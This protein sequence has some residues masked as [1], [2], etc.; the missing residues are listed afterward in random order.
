MRGGGCSSWRRTWRGTMRGGRRGSGGISHCSRPSGR[1]ARPPPTRRWRSKAIE[2]ASRPRSTSSRR[3]TGRYCCYGIRDYRT[4]RLPRRRD[5][6]AA[7][8]GRPCRG[9][10]GG[11]CKPTRRERQVSMSHVDDGTLHAYLDGELSP[12]EARGIDAHLAQCPACRGRFDEERALITRAGEL[13]ALAAPPDR[14]L[15]PFRA[16]DVRPLKRLWWQVRLPL[17]WAATVVLA[18]GIGTYLGSG[19]RAVTDRSVAEP[20]ADRSRELVAADTPARLM[21]YRTAAE[22]R[23]AKR[24]AAPP[25]TPAPAPIPQRVADAVVPRADTATA[26]AY[27]ETGAESEARVSERNRLEDVRDLWKTE[28][29]ISIDSARRVLGTD[30]LVVPGVPIEAIYRGRHI[31]YS[32]V[33]IVEQ[34]LDSSTM[35]QV[36]N[37][38]SAPLALGEVVVTGAPAPASRADSTGA[39]ERAGGARAQVASSLGAKPNARLMFEET[40]NRP[41]RRVGNLEI[42]ISGPLPSDSLQRLLRLVQPVKP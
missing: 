29:A 15:P 40:R 39:L 20:L 42:H 14:E 17:A 19:S 10:A 38:R 13:L 6:R 35:I 3:A 24:A 22:P 9:R 18:L 8:S 1:R 30:P 25:A 36:I 5:W 27:V 7:R 31:G 12:A 4:R 11:W 23:V 34:A 37:A 32:A 21:P 26:R 28:S 41:L 33:V 2:R 16:G